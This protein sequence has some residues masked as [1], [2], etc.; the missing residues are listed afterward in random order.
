MTVTVKISGNE[1]ENVLFEDLTVP[2]KIDALDVEWFDE[3]D[4]TDSESGAYLATTQDCGFVT[5]NEEESFE[6]FSAERFPTL[7]ELLK[8]ESITLN[9]WHV[10]SAEAGLSA[11]MCN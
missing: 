6:V 5:L 3:D 4:L 7:A 2:E 11:A 9:D 10:A 8:D 1:I